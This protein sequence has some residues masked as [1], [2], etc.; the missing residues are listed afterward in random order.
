MES[1]G[2]PIVERRAIPREETEGIMPGTPITVPEAYFADMPDRY[3][4][5]KN[6]LFWECPTCG[7]RQPSRLTNGYARRGCR[8]EWA[9]RDRQERTALRETVNAQLKAL[10]CAN[11]YTWLGVH[12]SDLE[13]KTFE[14]Y[15]GR[16][17][18]DAHDIVARRARQLCLGQHIGNLLLPGDFGTGKTHLA[19][20][21]LNFLREHG[22]PCLFC[23]AQGLFD[24]LYAADF[25]SKERL[26]QKAGTAPAL[27]I[28]DLDKLYIKTREDKEDE[29]RYQKLTM[30]SILDIRYRAKL[31]T[32]ITT[33]EQGDLS[34]WLEGSTLDRLLG[35]CEVLPMN[36]ASYRR[37]VR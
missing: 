5:D 22:T 8:C 4:K 13:D 1:W 31:P 14:S 37:R 33:N 9:E 11:T 21:F 27:V 34:R 20:A 29:G 17:Q 3:S 30:R 12:E 35:N 23:T 26:L 25:A 7:P 15:E 36:G 18:P 10:R 24:A 28:D 19:A 32:I 6:A 2:L 16:Y